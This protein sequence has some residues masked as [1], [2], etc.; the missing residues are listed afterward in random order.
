MKRGA[1]NHPKMIE[2]ADRIE[3][4]IGV[5]LAASGVD[6][7]TVATGIMERLWHWCAE[8]APRGDVGRFS[9]SR[10]ARDGCRWLGD[11]AALVKALVDCGWLKSH[12]TH[13]LVVHDWAQHCEELVHK[14]L[15]RQGETFWCGS[16]PY[17]RNQARAKAGKEQAGEGGDDDRAEDGAN[18]ECDSQDFGAPVARQRRDGG[19]TA[20]SEE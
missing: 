15:A 11:P 9:D 6:P 7:L 18:G 12:E 3:G 14:R 17:A 13:R 20:E 16:K 1:P 4:L 19:A 2:L 10:I 5:A 8:Y